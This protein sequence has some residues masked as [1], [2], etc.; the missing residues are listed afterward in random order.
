VP[1][2]T[3]FIAFHAGARAA[4]GSVS[5]GHGRAVGTGDR[6]HDSEDVRSGDEVLTRGVVTA[7]NDVAFA[8]IDDA[9][10]DPSV[11]GDGV[12]QHRTGPDAV[13]RRGPHV[14]QRAVGDP[15]AHAV[16]PCFET[17]SETGREDPAND[18]IHEGRIGDEIRRRDSRGIAPAEPPKVAAVA[19]LRN[20]GG[21]SGDVD[22]E[23]ARRRRIHDGDGI[24]RRHRRASRRRLTEAE[25]R[26]PESAGDGADPPAL[27]RLRRP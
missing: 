12:E 14:E 26:P 6:R 10:S 7:E 18:G 8:N 23:G 15:G 21:S 24:P 1:R 27:K 4:K 13:N 22:R 5:S 11:K 16:A 19:V 3:A 25:N 2:P 17:K 9:M 20:L